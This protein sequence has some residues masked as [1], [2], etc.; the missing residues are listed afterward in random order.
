ML[1]LTS[2][3]LPRDTPYR[4]RFLYHKYGQQIV[5][6]SHV[7]LTSTG[8]DLVVASSEKV[9]CAGIHLAVNFMAHDEEKVLFWDLERVRG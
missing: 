8:L 6:S 4:F 7:T 3:G 5:V 9:E 1:R 2:K